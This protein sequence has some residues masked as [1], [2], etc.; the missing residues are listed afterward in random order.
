M[1]CWECDRGLAQISTFQIGSALCRHLALQVGYVPRMF[2]LVFPAHALEI[3]ESGIWGESDSVFRVVQT[4]ENQLCP[5]IKW[6]IERHGIVCGGTSCGNK[7]QGGE[8]IDSYPA[9]SLTHIWIQKLSENPREVVP[10]TTQYITE[11][12]K[13]ALILL[14]SAA[15]VIPVPLI[16]EAIKVALKIIEICE[17]CKILPRKGCEMAHNILLS[18]YIRHQGKGQGAAR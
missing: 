14:Q 15:N 11:T 1:P 16:Q 7:F 8:E 10:T 5:E 18:E 13:Q 12:G 2:L 4:L 6:T 9:N 3:V 17:V